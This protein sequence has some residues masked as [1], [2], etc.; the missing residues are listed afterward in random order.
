MVEIVGVPFAL[1]KP[2]NVARKMESS[3]SL[4]LCLSL[5]LRQ[6]V[7]LTHLMMNESSSEVKSFSGLL[8]RQGSCDCIFAVGY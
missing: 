2:L 7:P 1:V 5:S 8:R 4:A 6:C 3:T